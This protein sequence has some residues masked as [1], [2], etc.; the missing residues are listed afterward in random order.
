M[1]PETG[2]F[3]IV[4]TSRLHPDGKRP[5]PTALRS[6]IATLVAAALVDAPIRSPTT[7]ASPPGHASVRTVTVTGDVRCGIDVLID[8]GF[9][10]LKGQRVGLLTNHTGRTRDGR[11]TIDVLAGST[12][13]E[14]GAVVQPGARDSRRG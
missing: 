4:L 7:A 10:M 12:G 14:A 2:T 5:A 11:S 13:R 8:D 6:E 9:Q 3:V 1:D